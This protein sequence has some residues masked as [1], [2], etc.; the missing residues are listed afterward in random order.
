MKQLA[1]KPRRSEDKDFQD[2]TEEVAR[3]WLV[4][5]CDCEKCE[6]WEGA[7]AAYRRALAADP[8]Y[9]PVRYFTYNN[10]GYS[11]IQVGRFDEAELYCETAI[12]INPGQYNAHKNRGLALAGQG[13]WLDAALSLAEAASLCPQN[14]RAWMHLGQLLSC[15]PALL[16]QSAELAALVGS[17]SLQYGESEQT[18]KPH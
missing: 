14:P 8:Q 13:R 6:D 12:A 7:I 16:D 11:L 9:P 3:Y 1:E 10:L 2:S 15:K 17:L 5:G 18:Q 4:E